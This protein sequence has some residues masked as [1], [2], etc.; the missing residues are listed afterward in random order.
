MTTTITPP[1]D[2]PATL[3]GSPPPARRTGAVLALARFEARD[4]APDPGAVFALYV[5]LVA[6]RLTRQEGMDDYPI[7]H[8]VDRDT[9]TSPML[10]AIALLICTNAAALRSRKHGTVQQFDV[11]ALEPWRRTLAHLLSVG[12]VRGARGGRRLGPPSPGRRSSPA[13]SATAPSA[14]WPW[15]P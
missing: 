9:Q 13:R 5:G 14:N 10:L 7:L 2:P 6:V 11:L 12:A 1:S 3:P 4:S 15:D 8:M